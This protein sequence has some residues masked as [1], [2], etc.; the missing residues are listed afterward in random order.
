MDVP[1][2]NLASELGPISIDMIEYKLYLS[3]LA[4]ACNADV[5]KKYEITHILTVKKL[6][7]LEFIADDKQFVTMFIRLS[8]H[9]KQDLLSHFDKTHMFIME[10]LTKG[11]VLVHCLSGKSRSA[12]VVIAH[13]MKKY[14]ISFYEAFEKVK[15]KRSIIRPNRGFVDQLKLYQKMSFNIDPQ[16]MDYKVHRLFAAADRVQKLKILPKP[17]HDVIQPDP[18]QHQTQSEGHVFRCLKCRRI[19]ATKLNLIKHADKGENCMKTYFIEPLAWM[20]CT[21]ADT[22]KLQ[23]PKC[24]VKLGI[25]SWIRECQCL[26]GFKTVPAFCLKPT[27]VDYG[28]CSKEVQK[29]MPHQGRK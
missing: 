28:H 13:I 24:N 7:V 23:C 15:A 27:K 26:C 20:N 14:G 22:A 10:G 3:G 6:P 17:F 25:F 19:I 5:L 4:A 8:D 29:T 16:N 18:G 2:D 21:Q 11:A 9:P 1:A 12:S